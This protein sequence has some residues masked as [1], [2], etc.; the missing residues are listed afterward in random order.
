MIP[1]SFAVAVL[2]LSATLTSSAQPAKTE[3]PAQWDFVVR[4]DG[5]E[6]GTHRFERVPK[7][8]GSVAVTSDARFDVKLLG[9]T[10]YRYRH[11][12]RERWSGD[13]LQALDAQTDD[14]GKVTKVRGRGLAD[15]FA[16]EVESAS[17]DKTSTAVAAS[18]V[19]SFAYWNDKLASQRRLLDPCT[20]RL[21]DVAISA[22]PSRE[23][24]ATGRRVAVHGWRITGLPS[25]IDVWYE[26]A[27]WVGLDTT[28]AAGRT[29]S[30]RLR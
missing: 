18:C 24:A 2:A 17:N 9:W 21:V 1:R 3:S 25:P 7:G 29:L 22:L 11:R 10:A 12:N 8:D 6:V 5:D 27:E 15:G 19:M 13:C 28:V 30:Y 14:G 4:L 16:V 20:G 26:G 23:W